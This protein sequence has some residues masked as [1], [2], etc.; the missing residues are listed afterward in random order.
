MRKHEFKT[1]RKLIIILI[2]IFI[3]CSSDNKNSLAEQFKFLK[4]E[5]KSEVKLDFSKSGIDL[6]E[7]FENQIQQN[8]CE[9]SPYINGL[10]TKNKE[11]ISFPLVVYKYCD[12]YPH[13]RN[14]ISVLVNFKNEV[15]IDQEFIIKSSENLENKII[16]ATKNLI[17]REN[18]TTIIY[19]MGWDTEIDSLK[20]TDRFI[21]IFSA[22]KTLLNNLSLEKYN[23]KIDNLTELELNELKKIY[24]PIIGI[25]QGIIVTE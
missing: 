21:E 6:I 22:T 1:L 2:L 14:R 3:S 13:F 15:L 17:E 20:I 23:K 18:K 19:L 11:E 24:N 25:E 16:R 4:P 10:I 7:D 8:F 12:T 5:F 9:S